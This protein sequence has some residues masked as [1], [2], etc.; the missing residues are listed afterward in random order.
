M[1]LDCTYPPSL[2]RQPTQDRPVQ[3]PHN[4]MES[5]GVTCG[6]RAFHC[7]GGPTPSPVSVRALAG[8]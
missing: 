4:V 1:L 5:R 3:T 8:L 2:E 6:D 7:S